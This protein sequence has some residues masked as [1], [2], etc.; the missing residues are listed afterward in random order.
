MP[1]TATRHFEADSRRFSQSR[2]LRPAARSDAKA[3]TRPPLQRFNHYIVRPLE[4]FLPLSFA[5]VI[6]ATL[7]YGWWTHGEQHLT[8]KEGTGYWLGILGATLML[9]LL[10]YPLRKR[11]RSLRHLGS[12]KGWF[13]A[14]MMFGIIGPLLII[15][16]A[17]FTLASLNATVA[18]A[19]MLIVV[20]SGIVGR[21]LHAR[22][23]MGLYGR[24][25]EAQDLL[26]DISSMKALLATDLGN[27]QIFL[28]QIASLE[29]CLPNPD[30]GVLA[31]AWALFRTG[32]RTRRA[33]RH[34]VLR[35]KDIIAQ[36]AK[37]RRWSRRMRREKLY[38][39]RQHVRLFR[40]AIV[41]TA[42]FAVYARLLAL[43][44]H[45]HL[46]LF[47]LLIATAVMHIIAV[48]LY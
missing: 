38:A 17:N 18:T 24:R 1:T 19:A 16:H 31:S 5:A 3:L 39:V 43:W 8:P 32:P 29:R 40:G 26:A 23:H 33:E 34:L 11:V 41:K 30:R 10:L 21:Y 47:L 14:H 13:R 27:D 4:R 42:T 37:V 46:P 9:L 25:A 15:F 2:L 20:M 36:E 22:V 44:H 48:H 6:V 12:V 28:K 35:A 45:L 7:A